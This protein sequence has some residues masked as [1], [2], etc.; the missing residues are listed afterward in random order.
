MLERSC[1]RVY[2]KYKIRIRNVKEIRLKKILSL[3]CLILFTIFLLQLVNDEN[4]N[5]DV[6]HQAFT[7]KEPFK[8]YFRYNHNNSELKDWHDYVTIVRESQRT[9][10]GEQGKAVIV[11]DEYKNESE[12]LFEIYHHNAFV[13]ERIAKDRSVPDVRPEACKHFKYLSELPSVSVIIPFRDEAFSTLLRTVH[14]VVTRS[15][16][17]LLKEVI[18]ANDVSENE[19]LYGGLE[20]YVEE[21]FGSKVKIRVMPER[22]GLIKTRLAAA[23][24]AKGD[25]LVFL[26]C[27][28]EANVNWLPP[29]IEPIAKNYRIVTC[30]Y[31][32][33]INANTYAYEGRTSGARGGFSW[34]MV[35]EFMSVRPGDQS[36]EADPYENPIMM[37]CAFAISSKFFWELGGYDNA[38]DIWGGEQYELSFK[39]WLCGGKLLD[40]PCSRVAHLYRKR[41]IEKIPNKSGYNT[42][43]HMR[44]AEIWMDEYKNVF[45]GKDP[46]R[47]EGMEFGDISYMLNIKK[48][49]KCKPFKYFLEVVAPDIVDRYPPYE[50]P[51]FAYGAIQSVSHSNLCIDVM[52]ITASNPVELYPCFKNL[53]HPSRHQRFRLRLHRDISVEASS[54]FCLD[55]DKSN[56]VIL[57]NCFFHQTHPQYFRYDIDTKQIYCGHVTKN[58]KCIDCDPIKKTVF[59]APC[60]KNSLTQKW[61]WG[62]TNETM[63]RNWP[64]YGKPLKDEGDIKYFKLKKDKLKE[65]LI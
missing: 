4:V 29:L 65:N 9:G 34:D 12:S 14:S 38:L 40:I 61:H 62:V 35:Y 22:Y 46:Q 63:L 45:Y 37:G 1:R 51:T 39:T 54:N 47:F 48:K 53:T 59:A 10:D 44:V 52:K 27:H 49:L 15:P 32:D 2:R 23:R 21:H 20:E 57:Y 43:N 3:I 60:N 13:S 11:A 16:P 18:L 56:N 33:V 7:Y 6:S 64:D 50:P 24:I 42:R 36:D 19:Y 41:V 30:P 25:V 31:I 28:T 8:S 26:D 5:L 55:V 58:N 17:E